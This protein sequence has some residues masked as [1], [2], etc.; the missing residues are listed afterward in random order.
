M[1]LYKSGSSNIKVSDGSISSSATTVAVS[2]AAATELSL[3]AASTTPTAG[4]SDNLTATALDDYGNTDTSY[5]GSHNLT[6]SGAATSPSGSAPTVANSS[7]EATAFG[8]T[9]VINFTSGVAKV[10]SSKNGVMK[11]YRAEAAEISVSDGSMANGSGLGKGHAV[12]VTSGGGT[13]G[14]GTL[15]IPSSGVAESSTGFTY[16]SRASGSF[17]DTIT[18][19]TSEGTSYTSATA[20]A[21]S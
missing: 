2:A 5:T 9:T 7:G 17:T 6:F 4:A 19:A 16:T 20:T 21:S 1:R 18:A 14:G 10:S 8:N 11:L 15:A 13:I 12:K 3:T